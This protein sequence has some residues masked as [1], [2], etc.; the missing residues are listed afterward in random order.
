[1]YTGSSLKAYAN[2]AYEI[3]ATDTAFASG[4]VGLKLVAPD[5]PTA[6]YYGY[7]DWTFVS[8]YVSPEPAHSTWGSEE[9]GAVLKEVTDSLSLS[10]S[11]LRHKGI[12]PMTDVVGLADVILRHKTLAVSDGVGTS[13]VARSNKS[14][15]IVTDAV[16]LVDLINVIIGAIIKTVADAIGV[17]DMALL[18]K[19]AIIADAVNLADVAR[20]LKTMNVSD[21]LSLVDSAS[22]PSRV[23]R[24]LES[25]V[26]ADNAFVN[27]TLQIT[28]AVSIAEI[29]EVGAGGAKKTRL[30]LILGDLAVQLTGN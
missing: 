3:S 25:I 28:E 13:D 2:D 23:I 29:V 21:T 9:G 22:T 11:V 7:V 4:Y 27:K 24:A 10:D 1:M 16:S 18:N 20:A 15:L 8:K 26:L 19:T 12:L 30:F 14:P 5:S 17:S 6:T